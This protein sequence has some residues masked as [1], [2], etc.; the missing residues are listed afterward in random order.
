VLRRLIIS[1]GLG[2]AAVA[3]LGAPASA[4]QYPVTPPVVPPTPPVVDDD[5]VT[6]PP[7]PPV[8]DDNVVTPPPV[9]DDNVVTPPPVVEQVPEQPRDL[10]VA[11]DV[12][13]RTL[14]VTG[15]DLVG[16]AAIGAGALALGALLV[17]QR[18]RTS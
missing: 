14:P 1:F 15:G 2:L 17:A 3:L 9:V 11:G 10:E 16:L 4:Q 13:T 7:S 18:R 12:V 6:P 8:V 5:V